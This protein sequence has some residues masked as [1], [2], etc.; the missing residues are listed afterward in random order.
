MTV[1]ALAS[2][3]SS[4]LFSSPWRSS[5]WSTSLRGGSTAYE[6]LVRGTAG[7]AAATVLGQ[8]T[9]SNRYAFDQAC[10]INAI[11]LASRLGLQTTGASLSI[12]FIPGAMYH[13]ENCV[14]ATLR[15]AR[16]YGFPLD[17]LILG[18]G[19]SHGT[20]GRPRQRPGPCRFASG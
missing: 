12:N 1:A 19:L 8:I 13:P 11:E 2:M 15:A 10:R 18:T 20:T 6:A 5:L 3:A 4:R 16:K 7:E 14:R 9:L 17:G